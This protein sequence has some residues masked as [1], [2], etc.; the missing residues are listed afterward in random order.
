MHKKILITLVICGLPLTSF[1]STTVPPFGA[2]GSAEAS[3][4]WSS[5]QITPAGNTTISFFST[6]AGVQID[7]DVQGAASGVRVKGDYSGGLDANLQ[8]NYDFASVNRDVSLNAKVDLV[9]SNAISS[10]VQNASRGGSDHFDMSAAQQWIYIIPTG[11]STI[12]LRGNYNLSI[13]GK[14]N[15]SGDSVW[16]NSLAELDL[17]DESDGKFWVHDTAALEDSVW[18]GNTPLSRTQTGVFDRT[19]SVTPDRIY[20]LAFHAV[21]FSKVVSAPVPLPAS[22]ALLLTGLGLLGSMVKRRGM[23]KVE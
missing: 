14:A 18:A 20:R 9:N 11:E 8:R 10:S 5:V 21:T 16:L 6:Y 7:A 4:D 13:N 12:N 22:G 2:N 23:A 19:V 15:S 1:A 17:Y 3:I